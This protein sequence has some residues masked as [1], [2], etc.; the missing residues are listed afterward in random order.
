MCGVFRAAAHVVG[1]RGERC[2]GLAGGCF[3]ERWCTLCALAHGVVCAEAH[4][5]GAGSWERGAG[6]AARGCH[7]GLRQCVP[8]ARAGAGTW[9]FT[10]GCA[11]PVFQ[12]GRA[13]HGGG[14][15]GAGSE[16]RGAGSF[17]M[18]QAASSQAS[19]PVLRRSR[20]ARRA[21][22]PSCARSLR[23]RDGSDTCH[24]PSH[25]PPATS[26]PLTDYRIRF[27]RG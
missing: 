21:V 6:R 24:H 8:L 25:Q 23:C 27:A 5:G 26:H 1:A 15:W 11:V 12:T 16:G 17:R 3:C 10:P 13:S 4:F 9:G 20:T 18:R 19:S 2:P 14:V 22:A 7:P